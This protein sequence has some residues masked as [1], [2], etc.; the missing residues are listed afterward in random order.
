MKHLQRLLTLSF[1]EQKAAVSTT[2]G[3]TL[4]DPGWWGRFWSRVRGRTILEPGS[5]RTFPPDT[6]NTESGEHINDQS[7]LRLSAFWACVRLRSDT[8]SSL[9]VHVKNARKEVATGH[10]LYNLLHLQPN[11]DMTSCEFFACMVVCLDMWGNAYAVIDRSGDGRVL[12]LTPKTPARMSV[13][14]LLNGRLRYTYQPLRGDPVLY[15]EDQILHFRGLSMDGVMGLSPIEYAAE[16]MGDVLTANRA[17]SREYRNAMKVGGFLGMPENVELQPAQRTAFEG[18]LRRFATDPTLA[19]GWFLLEHGIKPI[20]GEGIRMSPRVAQLL[21]TRHF[22]IEEICRTLG[23][24]PPLIGHT[25]KASSWASSLSNLNQGF[26][27]YSI[28]PTL[29]RMEQRMRVKLIAAA[30]RRD[31]TV[32]FNFAALLRGNFAEQ[33]AAYATALQNGWRCQDEIRDFEDEPPLPNG[34]GQ[35]YR[36][37]ANSTPADGKPQPPAGQPRQQ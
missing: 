18:H 23:V 19:G 11:A 24:P 29:V 26:L 20:S 27:T 36:V 31:Y 3:G 17:A 16:I 37:P 30:E 32:R 7:A 33:T 9:P 8:I 5:G 6:T 21:E 10:D 25:D 22:G 15:D 34:Q 2:D 1:M 4:Q 28:Y 13:E 14:R 12:T 35:V